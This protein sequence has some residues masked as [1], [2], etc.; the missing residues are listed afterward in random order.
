MFR[1]LTGFLLT[2]ILWQIY[3]R[4]ISRYSIALTI[5]TA[6]ASSMLFGCVWSILDSFY[7]RLS[8]PAP[9]DILS[10]LLHSPQAAINYALTLVVW[11]L[12]YFGIKYWQKAQAQERFALESTALAQKAQLEALR[13]QINP[14]F[15]FNAL[16]SIRASIEE[17]PNGAKQMITQLSEFLRYSLLNDD[18]K[19][20]PL[21]DELA[22]LENYLAIEKTRFENKLLVDFDINDRAR[23]SK[24][25]YLLLNPL[26][27]NAVKHGFQTSIKPLKIKISADL[28][29]DDLCVEVTNT[30]TLNMDTRSGETGIGLKNVR[31]RIE[32][33]FGDNGSLSM[34]EENGLVKVRLRIPHEIQSDHY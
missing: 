20:V 16:N 22:A 23:D 28:S 17:N 2:C 34:L 19:K 10:D 7:N 4:I 30:G 12:L 31:E 21:R 27:E 1:A 26:V 18:A 25:P 33:L 9:G 29:D 5:I 3:R 6:L 13:Y 32:N 24:I 14:H 15:L 11:S 8:L